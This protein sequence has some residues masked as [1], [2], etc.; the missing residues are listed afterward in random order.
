[1]DD[2]SVP[3]YV[4]LGSNLGDRAGHLARAVEMLAALPRTTVARVSSLYETKPWGL[5]G[6]PDF[7]NAVA[8]LETALDPRSLLLHALAIE[9]RLGRVRTVR[10]GP[11]TVDIDLLVYDHLTLRDPELTLPHPRM[12]QR[13]FVLVPLAEIAPGLVVAGRTVADH[14]AALGDVGDEV[15]PAGALPEGG[16]RSLPGL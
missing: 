16:R 13:A 15:R 14:L 7:L 4:G 6:Q 10:W 1:M 9:S 2:P 8:L 11:R 5:A 12:L 3:V